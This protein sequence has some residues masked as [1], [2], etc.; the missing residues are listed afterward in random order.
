MPS[1]ARPT[2]EPAGQFSP[3]SKSIAFAAAYALAAGLSIFST[4]FAVSGVG[5]IGPASPAML[6]LLAISYALVLGLAVS[7]G[8]RFIRSARGGLPAPESGRRLHLRFVLLFSA[9]AVT[10]AL[11][12]ALFLGVTLSRGVDQWFSDQVS[13]V[14]ED[15]AAVGRAYLSIESESVRGEVLAMAGDLNSAQEGLKLDANAYARYL[16]EQARF[17]YF[18]SARV[19]NREEVLALAASEQPSA[20]APPRAADFDAADQSEMLLREGHQGIET[21]VR[22]TAYEN[23]YLQV[24]RPYDRDITERLTRWNQSTQDYRVAEQ[25]RRRIQSIFVLSYV[26]TAALVLVGA[27]WIGLGGASRIAGPIGQ[28]A[29]A[30]RRVAGG[31]LA[32]RVAVSGDRDEIDALSHAFNG[33][34]AQLESQHADLVKAREEAEQ[35]SQFTQAVLSGVSAGV[36]GIDRDQ[37]ITAANRSAAALLGVHD[38][39]RLEGRRLIDIA[40]EFC[41]L[42]NTVSPDKN[43]TYGMVLTRGGNTLHLQVR[44]GQEPGGLGQVITF[45]DMTRLVAAQRV[46]AWKDVARRIAHEIK[47]PLTP[48][49][50]SAERLRRKFS[51]EITS[52][53]ETFERCTQTILRQVSDIGRMVEE[54]SALARMP[55]PKLAQEDIGELLRAAAYSQSIAFEDI[56]FPVRSAADAPILLECDGRL[57]AQ[58][59]ANVLKNAAESIQARRDCEGEPKMGRVETVVQVEDEVLVIEVTD[60]GAGFPLHNR[61]Q[62]VEPY[63]TTRAKGAGLGLAIVLRILED[64]G[65]GLELGDSTELGGA[66]VRLLLPTQTAASQQKDQQEQAHVI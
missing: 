21:L 31:D 50:L 46:E 62:L 65:G 33:M 56:A 44:I 55:T 22:L 15:A 40:P 30:A 59:Y 17:R 4:V 39:A 34:T 35:R 60:N 27:M 63:V 58:A 66:L 24:F 8:W 42:L 1:G 13:N 37:R 26:A 14:V 11:V 61:E 54:F 19:L 47:N 52:D 12:V 57:L 18:A 36:I 28:L 45:D 20:F 9:G 48:I 29:A 23:A 49:Q 7:V 53:P 43:A 5:S 2:R 41:E 25:R 6:W 64:H 16:G 51:K 3:R 10:P 38:D 32:A